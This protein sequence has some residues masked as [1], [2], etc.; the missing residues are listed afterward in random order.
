MTLSLSL[1]EGNVTGAREIDRHIDNYINKSMHKKITNHSKHFKHFNHV[2]RPMNIQ[3]ECYTLHLNCV[4]TLP[5][6]HPVQVIYTHLLQPR[7]GKSNQVHF[8]SK[9]Y[10]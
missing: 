2:S 10:P 6:I 9:S 8:I 7:K 1:L 3:V 5:S 4:V